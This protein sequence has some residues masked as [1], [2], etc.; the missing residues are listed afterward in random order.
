M[1]VLAV[2]EVAKLAVDRAR[3]GGGPS[4]IEARTYR[5]YGHFLGDSP[6]R[7]RLDSEVAEWRERDPIA[8]FRCTVEE[9]AMLDTAELDRIDREVGAQIEAAVQFAEESPVPEPEALFEDVYGSY[10]EEALR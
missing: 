1:D 7:Y 3:S 6:N 4:F 5:F 10:P 8:L 2:Y 9:Q